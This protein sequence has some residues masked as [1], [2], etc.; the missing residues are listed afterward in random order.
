MKNSECQACARLRLVT[1]TESLTHE[2]GRCHSQL[3]IDLNTKPERTCTSAV[4]PSS[5]RS[6]AQVPHSR[7][8]HRTF[9]VFYNFPSIFYSSLGTTI[10]V[11]QIFLAS[12]SDKPLLTEQIPAKSAPGIFCGSWH[13]GSIME[14]TAHG[15]RLFGSHFS[16]QWI[17]LKPLGT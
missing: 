9:K 13:P 6:G 15:F 7:T 4:R 5:L 17:A 11:L 16:W 14:G 2:C 8:H 3:L 12:C 1:L 10:S